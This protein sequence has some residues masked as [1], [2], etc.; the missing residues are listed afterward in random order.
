MR[1]KFKNILQCSAEIKVSVRDW[2]NLEDVRK[3]MY[4]DR[5]ISQD[6][7]A[8]WLDGLSS[9][10]KNEFFVVFF[11]E[12]PIG[13]VSINNINFDFKSAEWAFYIF[14]DA[15]K[16]KGLGSAIEMLLLDEV[17]INRD[18]EKLNCEVIAFN[19][20][21]VKLH[22][23]FGFQVEGVRRKNIVKNNE[24]MDVVLLGILKEEWLEK[25]AGIE[26]IVTR[27]IG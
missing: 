27:L 22:Q 25:R 17:F 20:A 19:E 8:K 9:S 12:K 5:L 1:L 2:R 6:E 14:D 10:A 7:H 16:Q 21:V 11:D 3:Y 26:K 13:A 15:A 4:T 18:F 23:K 24:R